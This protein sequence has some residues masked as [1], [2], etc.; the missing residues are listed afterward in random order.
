MNGLTDLADSLNIGR[1]QSPVFSSGNDR[2]R[3]IYVARVVDNVDGSN[4]GRIKAEIVSFNDQNGEEQPGK[5]KNDVEAKIAYPLMYQFVNVIPRVGE[6]VYVFLENP[7]DQSSNRYYIGPIRSLS[8]PDSEYEGTTLANQLFNPSTYKGVG[9]SEINAFE[10][11]NGIPRDVIYIKGKKDSDISLKPREVLIRAGTYIPDTNEKNTETKSYIQ[12]KQFPDVVEIDPVRGT[13]TVTAT[14]FS[15][16]NIVGSNINL[17]SSDSTNSQNRA[18]DENGNLS[19]NKNVENSTNTRLNDYGTQAKT[20]HPLVL[21]DE[22]VKVLKVLIKFCL[23]H[24]HT[25]Q[26]TPYGPTE[27]INILNDFLADENISVILSKSVRTN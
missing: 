4:M 22:L 17:I 10:N 23:N 3:I 18:L 25:P 6:L 11:P 7:K 12:I 9:N 15:Q 2:G 20:L 8:R 21:G 26:E 24:K 14:K 1:G 16:V 5:D 27:E 19:D 13:P